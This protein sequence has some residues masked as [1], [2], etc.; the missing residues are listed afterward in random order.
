MWS[1]ESIDEVDYELA[2]HPTFG[3]S[4]LIRNRAF[5]QVRERGERFFGATDTLHE[6]FDWW[7]PAVLSALHGGVASSKVDSGIEYFSKSG[8]A[9]LSEL[10][11]SRGTFGAATRVVVVGESADFL[12]DR[13]LWNIAM[14]QWGSSTTQLRAASAAEVDTIARSREAVVDLM[15]RVGQDAIGFVSHYGVQ[16]SDEVSA[17]TDL[18]VPGFSLISEELLSRPDELA[19]SV[20]HEAL[21]SKKAIIN[22]ASDIGGSDRESDHLFIPWRQRNE[23]WWSPGRSLDALH[24]YVH[25]SLYEARRWQLARNKPDARA[26]LRRNI[27]RSTYLASLLLRVEDRLSPSDTEMLHWISGLIPAPLDLS[28]QGAQWLAFGERDERGLYNPDTQSGHRAGL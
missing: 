15:G 18:S 6:C 1:W 2:S 26:Q 7:H 28:D 17:S 13:V 20:F 14:D 3:N 19:A 4:T 11:A 9:I 8:K 12:A 5:A 10:A 16:V 23:P 22:M 21:H 25:M 27:F 24:V